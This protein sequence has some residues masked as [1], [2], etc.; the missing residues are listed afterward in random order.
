MILRTRA[1]AFL[2]LS[3]WLAMGCRHTA[4][5]VKDDTRK[6]LQKTGN[7]IKKAGEK[8]EGAGK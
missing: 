7:G 4:Q 3:A 5:G 1:V 8:V 2:L 6:A